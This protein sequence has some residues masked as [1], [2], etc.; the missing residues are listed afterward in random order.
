MSCYQSDHLQIKRELLNIKRNFHCGCV[1]LSYQKTTDIGSTRT[2]GRISTLLLYPLLDTLDFFPMSSG[3]Y[4]VGMNPV[5]P[6]RRNNVSMETTDF[7]GNSSDNSNGSKL[8]WLSENR[9]RDATKQKADKDSGVKSRGVANLTVFFC[10]CCGKGCLSLGNEYGG[11]EEDKGKLQI[12]LD[13]TVE[14][15]C[16]EDDLDA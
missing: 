8:H 13:L 4:L 11:G 15:C 7:P 3:C 2:S 1:V 9:F 16:F 12:P 10:W 5:E 14:V 6:P